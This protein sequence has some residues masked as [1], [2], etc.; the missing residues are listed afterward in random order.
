MHRD[1]DIYPDPLKFD[2]DRFLPE[3]FAKRHPYAFIP[4]SAGGRNCVGQ[5]FSMIEQKLVMAKLLRNFY[6]ESVD[7]E[8]KLVIVGEMILKCKN[9][10]RVRIYRRFS[11]EERYC[12]NCR[13]KQF[14]END[15]I[16][17]RNL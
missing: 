11:E 2:P 4:F 9:G 1:P 8:D 15:E 6:F 17:S 16:S 13:D 5:K 14:G 3:N 7:P 10:L 12:Q